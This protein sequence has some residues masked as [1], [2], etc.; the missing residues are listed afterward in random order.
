MR[1]NLIFLPLL[2]TS[3]A[4]S[5]P[6]EVMVTLDLK[7]ICQMKTQNE[8]QAPEFR[9]L[10]TTWRKETEND[11]SHVA[12]TTTYAPM[13]SVLTHSAG[14]KGRHIRDLVCMREGV[15]TVELETFFIGDIDFPGCPFCL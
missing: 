8:N 14:P 11:S 2:D 4:K 3:S 9:F 12:L 10:G 5:I 1:W 15:S 13:Q 6:F 7:E